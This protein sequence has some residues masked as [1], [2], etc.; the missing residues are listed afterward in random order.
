MST[1]VI[2]GAPKD[3]LEGRKLLPAGRYAVRLDGFKPKLSK[4]KEN[5]SVN[6]YPQ[7]KVVNNPSLN[8]STL[9]NPLNQGA[10]FILRDFSHMFGQMEQV[11]GDTVTIPGHF[12]PDP[13]APTDYSRFTYQG[14]LLGMVG[15]LELG[16]NKSPKGK[17]QNYIKA[18]YCRVAGCQV[19]HSTELT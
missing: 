10:G 16:V 5:P 14:P 7:L 8:G 19:N 3:S 15:E 4:N 13:N 12:M 6:L 9:F 2:L 17:D 11:I 1:P 18:Y